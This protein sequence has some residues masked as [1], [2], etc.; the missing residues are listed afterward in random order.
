M[1]Q[2]PAPLRVYLLHKVGGS[3][4][5]ADTLLFND[6]R[7]TP[8]ENGTEKFADHRSAI[9]TPHLL[10]GAIS[11]R[12]QRSVFKKKCSRFPLQPRQNRPFLK[13]RYRPNSPKLAQNLAHTPRVSTMSKASIS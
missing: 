1:A 13:L 8:P 6:Y 2:D 11:E 3:R 10:Y 5:R 12:C 9:R 4:A 7:I